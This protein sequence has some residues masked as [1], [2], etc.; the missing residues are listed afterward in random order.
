VT[1]ALKTFGKKA[2]KSIVQELLQMIQKKVWSKVNVNKLTTKQLKS[3][4]RSSMFLK[5]KRKPDG[6]FDKL[7]ARLVAGGNMQDKALYEDVSSPTVATS[8]ILIAAAIAAKERRTVATCDIGGAYLNANMG[9]NEVLMAI[10]PRL[11]EVLVDI[12]PAYR[13]SRRD[14]GSVVVKLEKALYG[15]VESAKLWYEH[16]RGT[17]ESFGFVVN[18]YD[19]CVFNRTRRRGAQCTICV[20]V[21]DLL[22]T[23][24]DRYQVEDVVRELRRVYGEVTSQI[25]P[26]QD[27]IGIHFDF[28]KPPTVQLSMTGIVRELLSEAEA[29]GRVTTPCAGNLFRIDPDSPLL[30]SERAQVFHSRVAKILYIAKRCRPDLLPLCAFL[31]TRVQAPTEEDWNKLD[32][33]VRYANGDPDIPLTLEI[34]EPLRVTVYADASYGVHADAKSHSGVVITL[35]AGAIYA[36]SSKQKLVTKSSAEAELVCLSDCLPQVI[37]VRNFLLAQ[38]YSVGPARVYQDNTSTITLAE[39]G[40]STSDKT[41]HVNIRY[42]FVKDRIATGEVAIEYLPTEE[43]VADVLTKPLQGARF[44][45]LRGALLNAG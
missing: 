11:A 8:S 34:K 32:R 31:T 20:H 14:D 26:V 30:S 6:S 16:L 3:I 12:A 15:C 27:Y 19:M 42:F 40:R 33:G 38:G 36:K 29:S 44:V 37:H 10:E 1:K 25:G 39:K 35:G 45:R 22:I 24:A 43:M 7:K 21:D 13:D 4:I 28:S 2:L 18:P 5:E 23:C 41:R 9:T 17:L